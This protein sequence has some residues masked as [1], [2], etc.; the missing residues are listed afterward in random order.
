MSARSKVRPATPYGSYRKA[1]RCV[2]VCSSKGATAARSAISQVG[3]RSPAD[4][5]SVR[6]PNVRNRQLSIGHAFRRSMS[7]LLGE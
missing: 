4:T 2:R 6:A 1:K 3:F 7:E 5:R